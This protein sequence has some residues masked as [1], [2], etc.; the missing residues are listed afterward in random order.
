MICNSFFSPDKRFFI[1]TFVQ[2][3]TRVMLDGHPT[4]VAEFS[5]PT[6]RDAENKTAT[7]CSYF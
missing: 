2:L 7:Q 6:I 3:R 1:N 5:S 4:K